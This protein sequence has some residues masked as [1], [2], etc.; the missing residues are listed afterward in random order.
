MEMQDNNKP[1]AICN[2]ELALRE[3]AGQAVA[4]H[5]ESVAHCPVAQRMFRHGSGE[6]G[7][8]IAAVA[9]VANASGVARTASE[10]VGSGL[11]TVK[12]FARHFD[13]RTLSAVIL[14]HLTLTEDMCNVARP[15]KPEALATLAKQISR[16][17]LDDDMSWNF[18][19]IQIVM[20]R[21]ASGEAGQVFGGLNAPMVTKAFTDYMAEKGEA[22]VAWR[23]DEQKRN[24][25]GF[26]AE[27][28]CTTARAMERVKHAAAHEAYVKGK[29]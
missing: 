21:L 1:T 17:L 24:D 29:L 19:D 16:M 10:S 14:T 9:V 15:M 12:M 23:E 5:D 25:N 20:D 18:A 11:T 13:E 4:I 26:G 3:S 8:P 7:F 27:R 6:D 2:G 28:S 22:Y